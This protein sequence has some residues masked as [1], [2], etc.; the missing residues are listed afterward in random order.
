MVVPVWEPIP[1]DRPEWIIKMDPDPAFGIGQYALTRMCLAALE[2]ISLVVAN[3]ILGTILELAPFFAPRL[4]PDGRLVLSG[5]LKDQASEV[6]TA[7]KTIGLVLGV[8]RSGFVWSLREL[9]QR[10]LGL[11]VKV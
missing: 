11:S 8:R 3:L 4:D 5:L 1:P 9:L 7:M 10:G 2:T 6:K